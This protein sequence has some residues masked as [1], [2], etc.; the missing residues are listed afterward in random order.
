MLVRARLS[1]G[2]RQTLTHSWFV[3]PVELNR[4]PIL[5]VTIFAVNQDRVLV[6]DHPLAGTQFPAGTVD[7]GESSE[8]AAMRE[9][10]EETGIQV[11]DVAY[12][13][14]TITRREDDLAYTLDTVVAD[15]GLR[16]P[17][18]YRVHV[19]SEEGDQIR[20]SRRESDHS[21]QPPKILSESVGRT[22][23]LSLTRCIERHF[24]GARVKNA[25]PWSWEGDDGH[26]WLCHFL[27]I[28]EVQAFGE[29]QG[30]LEE[31]AP[32][33]LAPSR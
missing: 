11:K 19:L 20:F 18:G 3:M 8:S 22:A 5:K 28:N 7:L 14:T 6:F 33:L 31:F 29:Q 2:C 24:Y 21:K 25:A 9:L 17:R 26:V 10:T 13:G 23:R 16:I 4:S 12:L 27:D 30:W 32:K 15:D 1:A